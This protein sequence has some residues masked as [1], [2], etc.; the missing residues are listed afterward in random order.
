MVRIRNHIDPHWR[1][2]FL[3]PDPLQSTILLFTGGGPWYA[4]IHNSF[5]SWI[6]ICIQIGRRGRILVCMYPYLFSSW[7]RICIQIVAV[8]PDPGVAIEL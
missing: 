2:S 5:S 7:I 8:D 3:N 6:R 1:L 4:C